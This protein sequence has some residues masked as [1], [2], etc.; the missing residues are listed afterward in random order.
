MKISGYFRA[1]GYY[2]VAVRAFVLELSAFSERDARRLE[3]LILAKRTQE[4]KIGEEVLLECSL[5]LPSPKRT[6]KQNSTAFKIISLLFESQEGRKPT[7]GEK[8]ALYYD[9]LETHADKKPTRGGVRLRPVHLSE[10]T[11]EQ[12]ARFIDGLLFELCTCC[13]L[14]QD[15]QADARQVI[16]EW[17]VWRGQQ[18]EDF[19]ASMTEK[20]WRARAVYSESSGLGGDIEL[21]HI[22]P[23]GSHPQFADDPENWMALTHWE[24]K[25]FHDLGRERF[26]QKYPHLAGRFERM[27]LKA[28]KEIGT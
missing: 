27:E 10:A 21:H 14:P 25:E 1:R 22:L 13:D 7:E 23:K 3:N 18:K 28:Q 19:T 16:Y 6:V 12:A 8:K 24:H 26:L 20:E 4:E 2:N 15:L 11:T 17:E 9:L 5:E